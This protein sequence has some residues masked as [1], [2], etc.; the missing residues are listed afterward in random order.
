M[1][2]APNYVFEH[3]GLNVP[4]HQRA[5]AWYQDNLK[6]TVARQLPD[7]GAVFLADPT[8]RVVLEVYHNPAAPDLDLPSFQPLMLHFAFLVDDVEAR[9]HELQAAGCTV[10]D[11]LKTTPA[12][13][14]MIILRDPFGLNVQLIKRNEQMMDF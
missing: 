14:T 8:G 4:D 2:K 6:M 9:A 5:A 1:G 12:G 10:A 7:G 3:V 13:D 11:S